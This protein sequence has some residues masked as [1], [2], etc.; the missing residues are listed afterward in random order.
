M[1]YVEHIRLK[2]T[3]AVTP[4]RIKAYISISEIFENKKREKGN[5]A[6][7][8]IFDGLKRVGKAEMFITNNVSKFSFFILKMYML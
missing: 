7:K 2:R 5:R 4:F 6:A 3:P 1:L 8:S